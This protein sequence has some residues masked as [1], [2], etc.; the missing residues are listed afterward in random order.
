MLMT[1]YLPNLPIWDF[2]RES[3][4]IFDLLANPGERIYRSFCPVVDIEEQDDAYRVTVELPGISK[5]DIEINL[6]DN[7]LT[8]TGEKK[9]DKQI[10]QQ[11]IHQSERVYGKF[12]R[13]FRLPE[14]VDQEKISAEFSNGVLN[15]IIPKLA[16]AQPREIEVKVK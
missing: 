6:K 9:L 3:E 1:R 5:N 14:L 8:I 12:Q 13:C 10:E 11:K 16:E 15:I 2:A 4:R 7:V